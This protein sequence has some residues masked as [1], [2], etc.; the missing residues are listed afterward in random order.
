[1]PHAPSLDRVDVLQPTTFAIMVSL[2]ALWQAN[3]IHPDA[4]I[5][6]SQGEIAAAH[7]AGHLTLPT[8]TKIV[9]LRS[10]TIAHHLT[11]HGAM[12]SILTTPEWVQEALT[13]W[14]G[15]LWIAA[16][17]G[18]ASVSVSGDP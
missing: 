11:G 4:V 5:G 7:V 3:G 17:N 18:P 1:A 2:A 15:R 12:M 9:T 6:H 14:D 13:P 10:Q 16:V 8:A